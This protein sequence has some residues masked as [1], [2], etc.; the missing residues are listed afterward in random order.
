MSRHVEEHDPALLPIF[1]PCLWTQVLS[2][3]LLTSGHCDPSV[4]ERE[5]ERER[6]SDRE[7]ERKRFS[8]CRP[9]LTILY[10]TLPQFPIPVPYAFAL[11]MGLTRVDFLGI[12]ENYD[13]GGLQRFGGFS[14]N[15]V[16]KASSRVLETYGLF[17]IYKAYR[18]LRLNSQLCEAGM[19]R[20][21][22]AS[23]K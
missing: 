16:P 9:I 5:R 23:Q 6:D 14:L 8:P 7:R 20:G 17:V 2:S 19:T 13:C 22:G 21:E 11:T 18:T 3:G 1:S 15:K 10:Y 12:S 4:R